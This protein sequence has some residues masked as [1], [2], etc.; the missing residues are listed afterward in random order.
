MRIDFVMLCDAAVEVN[1]RLNV[2]GSIDL[3]WTAA[4]PYIHPKCALAVRMRWEGHERLRKHK[5]RV[6]IVD[7]DGYSI[8]TE[9]H[10]KFTAPVS[11]QED[12]PILRHLILELESLRFANYGPYA[13]R[14]EVDGVEEACLP[15]SVVP[16]H[17]LR[18]QRAA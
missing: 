3:F 17:R 18:Q 8:A 15:F 16:P 6:Q 5:V 7:A 2:L 14:V 9:F 4:L 11:Q 1:G 12:V 10:R 13:V